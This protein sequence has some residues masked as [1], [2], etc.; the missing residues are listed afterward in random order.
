MDGDLRGS[1]GV[2]YAD[3]HCHGG[4]GESFGESTAG[5]ARAAAYHAGRGTTTLVASLVTAPVPTLQAQIR[6]LAP[7][8]ASGVLA[9]IHLEGP[10]LAPARSGAHDPAALALPD[11]Q[12]VEILAAAAAA[13]GAPGAIRQLTF[14]PELPGAQRLVAA[15][16]R[17]G[18]LPA[19]GHTDAGAA[20]VSDTLHRIADLTGRRP[21][22][23]HLFNGMPP[24]HHRRGGPAAAALAAAARGECVV[25]LIAEGVHVGAEVVRMVFDTVGGSSVA[26]VSDAMAAA[27]QGDGDYGLGGLE[28]QVR[29]GEAR[30]APGSG[31]AGAT[32][33]PG[34]LAGGTSSIADQV[35]WC[36][37]QLHLDP[38]EVARAATGTPRSV[39][40]LG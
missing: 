17:H 32:G 6:R 16:A 18:I 40:D 23:T 36:T 19:V 34:S 33:T 11:P 30:V 35:A 15:L 7:L 26:L 12:A 29:G 3:V 28:V 37:E 13:A 14:A 31:V 1:T 20:V 22:V 27:G 10:Y 21:L 39:L 8:V 5:S 4:A 9:G 38:D 24:L 2:G 25:E